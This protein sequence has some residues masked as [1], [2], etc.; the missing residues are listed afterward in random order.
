MRIG[1]RILDT[2]YKAIRDREKLLLIL[3]T[4]SVNS[5]WVRDE[6]EKA[7][8]EER[9]RGEPV[10]FPIRT[11]DAVMETDMP[12]AEKI[13]QGRHIGDFNNWND[14]IAYE[15]S[16]KRLLRDLSKRHDQR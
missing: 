8:A 9:D 7:F 10:V 14:P 13:R 4:S 12:W 11:D 2:I 3:S 5:E 1:D 6:V 16:F 15:E